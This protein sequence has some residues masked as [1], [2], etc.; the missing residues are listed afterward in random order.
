MTERF[1]SRL[2]DLRTVLG[3]SQDEVAAGTGLDRTYISQLERALKS[4]TLTSLERL[5]AYFGVDPGELLVARDRG[6]NRPSV[7]GGSYIVR[8]RPRVSIRRGA[9]LLTLDTAPLILA[10]DSAHDLIDDI[11]SARLA[12]ILKLRNLSAFIGQLYSDSVAKHAPE[13]LVSNPHQDGYP[14]LLYLDTVGRKLFESLQPR[15]RD[16]EPF[17]PF[18]SGGIEVKATCGA[19]PRPAWFRNRR[20]AHPDLG[21][22][23]TPYLRSYDW[24]AHHRDTNNL[25]GILWDFIDGKPRI[26]A[27]FYSSSLSTAAWGD[28]VQ[29]RAGGGRTTSVS[30]MTRPGI[31]TM[32]DDWLL[33]LK[34]A[35]LIGFLNARNRSDAIPLP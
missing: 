10:V 30:I 2:R 9:A 14:D 31:R 25:A 22:S 15:L 5:A 3:R 17:S 1:A 11:Y 23:R 21:D 27:L 8:E 34:N 16:K 13:L 4:P 33:V 7:L 24:K 18:E 29:P 20:V 12:S 6:P 28:I 32:Y 19:L 26:T 35:T